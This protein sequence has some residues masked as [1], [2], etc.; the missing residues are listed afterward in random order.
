[1]AKAE[2]EKEKEMKALRIAGIPVVL[3]LCAGMA[4]GQDATKDAGKAATTTGQAVKHTGKTVGH[5]TK[6]GAKDAAHGTKTAGKDTVKGIKK[7]TGKS[8][9][10]V[11]DG[12][13]NSAPS[14]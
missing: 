2:T 8:G 11:D 6:S 4:L 7:V 3:I 14:K 5:A 9:K 1:M 10:K 12:T 13:S